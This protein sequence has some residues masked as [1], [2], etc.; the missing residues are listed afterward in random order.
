MRPGDEAVFTLIVANRNDQS[1]QDIVVTDPML[2][3]F[4]IVKVEATKGR[5]TIDPSSNTVTVVMESLEK[6]EEAEITIVVNVNNTANFT[7]EVPNT[8]ELKYEINGSENTDT[9]NTICLL[10][11]GGLTG[12][13]ASSPLS[14]GNLGLGLPGILIC[15]YGVWMRLRKKQYGVGCMA[16]GVILL[17]IPMIYFVFILVFSPNQVSHGYITFPGCG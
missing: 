3:Y 5:A 11:E 7:G 9:S 6:G 2:S 13:S 16:A 4:D 14:L 12:R 10:V 8:A 17:L 15:G 1:V